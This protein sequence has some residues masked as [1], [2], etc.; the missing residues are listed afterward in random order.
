MA[1][2][3][4]SERRRGWMRPVGRDLSRIAGRVLGKRGL[5]EA[6]LL[7]EWNAVVGAE[8]AAETL[9]LKLSFA[10]GGRKND[11]VRARPR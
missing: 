2:G 5:G 11:F 3:G 9:P 10:T 1:V 4:E 8:L 7:A 6:H